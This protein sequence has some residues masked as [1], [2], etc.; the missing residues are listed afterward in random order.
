M[1]KFNIVVIGAGSGGL[2]VAAGATGLGARVALVEKHRM[3]GDCLNTGC[4]PSKALLAAAKT[5][6]HARDASRLGLSLPDPGPQNWKAIQAWVRASQAHIAPHDSVERFTGLGVEVFQGAARLK[7]AHEVEVNGQTLWGRHI[8][9][10]TGSRA[11]GPP[12]PGLLEAGFLTNETVFEIEARPASLLV[13]GGGPIGTELGQAFARLGTAVTIVSSTPHICAKEDP[14]AA[15]VLAARLRK[16]GV[17]ILDEST[18]TRVALRDGKKI[19]T[20]KSPG[21]AETEVAADE[22]LVAVGRTPN[23]D[24][25]GLEAVG[26]SFTK[27]G[28]AIDSTC[29]TNVPSVWAIGDVAGGPLFT[30]WAGHQARVVIRN[31]LFPGKTNHDIE[32]LPWTTFTEPEI[33][34]VG[35]NETTAKKTNVAHRVFKVSF[36]GV[37]RAVCDGEAEGY[38]AKVVAGPDGE[39][40]GATIV[41]PQAGNLLPELVL[42]KKH[43]I[44]LGKLS[45]TIHT[46]PSLSEV[47]RA[48]GDA[49]MRTKLTAPTKARLT[50]AFRWLR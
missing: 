25:L 31:I 39:I 7:S 26:V 13:M 41:H 35:L 42:A 3:G 8:V 33:A 4:V 11:A 50:K 34:H 28:I 30:H 17:R 23:V 18:A 44:P 1:E 49:Y 9:V 40:L 46:Y 43:G 37:D 36:D 12:I 5:V 16:E 47:N 22:I 48:L 45:T 10:A 38:F 6:Q 21:G 20:V 2:V 19:V 24:G 14:D 27:R 29:Q 32:N 15:L